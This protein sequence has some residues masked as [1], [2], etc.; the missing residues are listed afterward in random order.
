MKAFFICGLFKKQRKRRRRL[1]GKRK[2]ASLMFINTR[3]R[4]IAALLQCSTAPA[5]SRYTIVCPDGPEEGET[6]KLANPTEPTTFFFPF[7]LFELLPPF[8]FLL[9]ASALK[10]KNER[11]QSFQ[12]E[13]RKQKANNKK[14]TS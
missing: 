5:P 9:S 6:Y 10:F 13:K 3:A 1:D 11:R 4:L 14:E 8:Y 7:F 2:R 12:K